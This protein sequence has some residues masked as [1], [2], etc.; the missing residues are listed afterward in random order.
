[1]KEAFYVYILA[2]C[3][4]GTLYIGMTSNLPKRVWE[5]KNKIFPECFTATYNVGN[6]VYY[7][8]HDNAR[9]A[10]NRETRLK[11]WQRNWK[12]D[13]IEQFNPE[14]RDLYEEIASFA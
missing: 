6:L 7:E 10:I 4:N 9:S 2:S 8:V 12:K 11:F 3:R 1:M 13:L 14:W 5:H